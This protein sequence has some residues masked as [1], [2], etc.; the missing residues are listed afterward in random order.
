[1]LKTFILLFPFLLLTN[2]N[3]AQQSI[4]LLGN[5]DGPN[6]PNRLTELNKIITTENNNN[7]VVFILGDLKQA[8]E[9]S[10]EA[11]V[12]FVT[13]N[14]KKGAKIYA[15]TGDL[16]WNNSGY[17]GLD[18]AA[19]FQK[20]FSEKL[21][22][23]I[24]IPKDVC[25][26]PHIKDLDE[27]VRIIAINSQWWLHPYRK[28][29]PTDSECKNITVPQ[30]I[31]E[32][33]EAI[34]TAG[35][36]KV[37]IITHHP[38]ISGGVYSGNLNAKAHLFPYTHN[39]P[40]DR[41]FR[42]IFGT[43]YHY[44][45]QNVGTNQDFSS[46]AYKQYIKDIKE[47][48][49]THQNVIVCSSHEYDLQLLKI[50]N[51]YQIVSGSFLKSGSTSKTK[52][53]LFNTKVSGFVKL[54]INKDSTISKFY[55]LNE[56]SNQFEI[57][58]TIPLI[59]EDYRIIDDTQ[60]RKKKIAPLVNQVRG[61]TYAKTNF[62]RLFVG[63][64]YRD[65]WTEPLTIST[66]NIDTTFGGLTP[67]EKGGGLQT[68][69]LKFKDQEGK[70]YAFR[71]IDKT[72]AK[73]LPRELRIDVMKEITQDM[74]ATQHPYGALFVASLLDATEIYHASP[75]LYV[76]P[77]SPV[78]GKY[79]EQF[80]G[81]FGMLE[82]KPTELDDL[83]KSY[84]NAN[85]VKSSLSLFK[86]LYDSPKTVIDTFQYAKARVFDIFIGDWDRHEDNWKWIGFESKDKTI[87]KPYPKDRDHAFSQMDGLFY[88]I[89]DR[90]WAFPFRENFGKK[91]TGIKSLTIKGSH[92][93]RLL[94]A[95]LTKQ[96]W[97][98]IA[99]ELNQQMTDSVIDYAKTAFPTEI[100]QNSGNAIAEK[101]KSR[102]KGLTEA[103]NKYYKLLAKKVEIVGTNEAEY[104]EVNRLKSGE[105]NIKIYP[106][107]NL[108]TPFYNR[109]F[110]RK[111]TKELRLFGL[112]A[113]D[114]FYINGESNKSILV[115]IA[116]GNGTDIVYDS[117]KT[118]SL[119]H[120][121]LV[122]DY[123]NGVILNDG[124]NNRGIYSEKMVLNEYNNQAYK[125]N[126]YIP[127]PVIVTN[128][129][130]GFG[131]GL[132]LNLTRYDYGYKEFKAK[133]TIK[134][135]ATTKGSAV[136]SLA[137]ER[138]IARSDLY[139]TSKAEYGNFFPF[140]SFYGVGNNTFFD[141]KIKEAEYYQARFEGLIIESGLDYKFLKTSSVS[142][143]GIAELLK[144]A[145]ADESYF[146]LFPS[147]T[148]H[149][150][151]AFGGNVNLDIDF[152][153]SKFFTTK[154]IQILA[155][156]QTLWSNPTR[157]GKTSFELTY[158][159]TAR[160]IIP[161]TL[162]IKV[163]T[164]RTYG[165]EIPFYHLA[166]LGQSN[167][168]RGFFQNRFSGIGA[169]YVNTDLRFHVGKL[170]SSFLPLYYGINLFADAGQITENSYTK[171]EWHNGYGMGIYICPINK[172]YI[173]IQLN[174][175]HSVEQDFLFKLK[176]GALF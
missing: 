115:R 24:F 113:R 147:P 132:T 46:E 28:L 156:H 29:L 114:S 176:I 85:Q 174:G 3:Y 162:G 69:S 23:N 153:D 99:N 89:A 2:Y 53:T 116:G 166:N 110:N 31:D 109:T 30:I 124:K 32:I 121:T 13:T 65:A 90:E 127:L 173:T 78:L 49:Y 67:T 45:R 164:E 12:N 66:L 134:G 70:E 91:I 15:V 38:I 158:Y 104:F 137:T 58:K 152:R 145:P 163:G 51:N 125:Y 4:Y 93:D 98:N 148:L 165:K 170:H 112:A 21:S 27:D 96:D 146:D 11:L 101:L 60:A 50:N 81:M 88:Y 171:E 175:E 83:S 80:K 118:R 133:H 129:D 68:I 71:S 20:E 10:E 48:L 128:P 102:K 149:A 131:G 54:E 92:L 59:D 117:S 79:R 74:T 6:L 100:Q 41:K 61:G 33:T 17:N 151:N 154:G 35:K 40:T 150:K 119:L 86:K 34:E 160:I 139:F 64:L 95:N 5:L 22:K 143:N 1:M 144:N 161:I 42:P 56:V 39:D 9:K 26:G 126:T 52:N 77:D 123:P 169:N 142:V 168:L 18:S 94:L 107:N 8:Y 135:F 55:T 122:Y 97:V 57:N 105:V 120:K 140:Y 47:L 75:K 73:S 14:R 37:I 76:M 43:F 62:L 36:R 103:V 7:Y 25:P 16:D 111:E 82:P 106:L 155:K 84:Q 172:E 141:E 167:H 19:N 108:T 157:F 63:D 44:Y 136:I 130:D 138:S 72:P 87:Y 159:N